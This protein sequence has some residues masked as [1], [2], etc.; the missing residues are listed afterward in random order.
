MTERTCTDLHHAITSN[1][2][3]LQT[4][5]NAAEDDTQVTAIREAADAL[6]RV[7]IR[8]KFTGLAG[9]RSRH[10]TPAIIK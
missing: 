4:R 7:A 9:M 1:L 3:H 10:I 8:T 5:L 2:I 6:M